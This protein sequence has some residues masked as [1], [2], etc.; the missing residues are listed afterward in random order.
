MVSSQWLAAWLLSN[1]ECRVVKVQG[2]EY[3]LGLILKKLTFNERENVDKWLEDKTYT[4]Y[5]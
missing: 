5:Q 2:F 1:T 4:I 3:L